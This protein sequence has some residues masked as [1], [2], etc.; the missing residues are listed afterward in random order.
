MNRGLMKTLCFILL[1]A[2]GVLAIIA[3][4]ADD[5]PGLQGLGLILIFSILFLTYRSRGAK[6]HTKY[7]IYPWLMFIFIM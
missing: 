5:S 1:V 7:L 3:G 2:I 6:S 4:E